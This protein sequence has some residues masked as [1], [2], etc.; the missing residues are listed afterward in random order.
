MLETHHAS[1]TWS[2]SHPRDTFFFT[3][4]IV[5]LIPGSV[6]QIMLGEAA[7]AENIAILEAELGLD[8]PLLIQYGRWLG[9]CWLGIGE[10][11]SAISVLSLKR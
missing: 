9:G 10:N 8:D 6:A 5:H 4:F 11:L 1:F 2:D 3:F 7:S